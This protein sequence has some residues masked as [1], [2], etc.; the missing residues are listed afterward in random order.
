MLS[1][2]RLLI[3]TSILI[4]YLRGAISTEILL[5]TLDGRAPLVS[6]V[7]LH[8]LRR[9]VRPGSTWENQINRLVPSDTILAAAPSSHEW[10]EAADVIR[11]YFNNRS[12][13]ELATLTNDVLIALTAKTLCAELWSRDR[14]FK[15]ICKAIGVHLLDH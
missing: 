9:G 2:S 14:D 15:L 1:P 3:D 7:T 11:N 6:P 12:K 8:E 4:S 10:M 5:R 13:I